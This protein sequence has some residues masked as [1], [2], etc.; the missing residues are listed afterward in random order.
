MSGPFVFF[1]LRTPDV[2]LSRAFYAGLAGLT[3]T[4]IPAGT[5]SIPMFTDADRQPWGG[6]TALPEGDPRPPQWIP[7]LPVEDLDQ[8]AHRAV[9][10]GATVIRDRVDLPQ[11]SVVVITDPGGATVALWQ[12]AAQ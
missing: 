2:A 8:A 1:D 4:E 10:L 12:D 9:E 6:L 5:D 11:G 3:I 7:Y